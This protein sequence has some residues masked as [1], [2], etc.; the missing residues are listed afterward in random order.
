MGNLRNNYS[1]PCVSLNTAAES[2]KPE[3]EKGTGIETNWVSCCRSLE[4]DGIF[5]ARERGHLLNV[6]NSC[7]DLKK[8]EKMEIILGKKVQNA[9]CEN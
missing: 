9:N 8:F 7:Y 4:E 3:L 5:Y 1:N 2:V 6:N